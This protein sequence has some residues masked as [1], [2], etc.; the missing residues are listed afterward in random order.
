[1]VALTMSC[2]KIVWWM[3]DNGLIE[4]CENMMTAAE[5]SWWLCG[6]LQCGGWMED[7]AGL[8]VLVL[9]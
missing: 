6:L 7:V 1:M 5:G 2:A 4:L 9:F 3:E 8:F